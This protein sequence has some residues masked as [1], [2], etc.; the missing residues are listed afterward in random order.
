M[1]EKLCDLYA[2]ATIEEGRAWFL[3]HQRMHPARSKA[4]TSAIN[5][6][7]GELRPHAAVL[8]EGLG[9]PETWLRSQMLA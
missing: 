5:A 6:L 1:L 2:L 9:V 3:E 4:V 7:C 8:V